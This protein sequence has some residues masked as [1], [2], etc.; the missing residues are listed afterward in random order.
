MNDGVE[1]YIV[2]GVNHHNKSGVFT[3]GGENV[4]E[5]IKQICEIVMDE[6]TQFSHKQDA[7]TFV[8]EIKKGL[9]IH[10]AMN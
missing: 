2:I 10:I 6:K 9:P 3:F 4:D 8:D 5:C 7:R 1:I